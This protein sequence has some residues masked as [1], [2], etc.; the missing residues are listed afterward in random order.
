MLLMQRFGRGAFHAPYALVL[1]SVAVA[2]AQEAE[3]PLKYD[4]CAGDEADDERGVVF[5]NEAHDCF[6]L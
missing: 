4:N 6:S 5:G 2:A 3:R 1:L